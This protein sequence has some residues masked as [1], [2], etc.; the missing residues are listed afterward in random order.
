MA[1]DNGQVSAA[2][3]AEKEITTICGL[4][5]KDNKQK[6]GKTVVEILALVANSKRVRASEV[7]SKPLKCLEGALDT[8][9]AAECESKEDQAS[10][11]DS[12]PNA[13]KTPSMG[14]N[15]D[16]K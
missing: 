5:E 13:N 12:A 7:D 4:Y 16:I 10:I 15:E 9:K 14:D 1:V 8:P 6:A 2:I 3:S 11:G